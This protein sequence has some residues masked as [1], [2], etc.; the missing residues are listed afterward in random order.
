VRGFYKT[1]S[2]NDSYLQAVFNSNDK[3][4]KLARKAGSGSE[5]TLA[6]WTGA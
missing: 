2:D 6:T 3:T 5:T 1:N 4:I